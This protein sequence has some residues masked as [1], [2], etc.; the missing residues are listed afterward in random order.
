MP[1]WVI[2]SLAAGHE[3]HWGVLF[4]R[5]GV[6]FV[7]GVAV[8][9][10][11]WATHRRDETLSS[12]FVATLI[13]LSILI[14]MLT[15]V[16]GD[17]TARAFSLLGVLS[18]VRFR[19]IVEDTRDTAFV[20]FAVIIGMA[21]GADHLAVALAGLL[22]VGLAAM[23]M[24]PRRRGDLSDLRLSPDWKLMVR[25]GL[26][27]LPA[28]LEPLYRKHFESWQP[29]RTSTGRQGAAIDLSYRVRLSPTANPAALVAEL[30]Q[31]EGVQQVDLERIG[32]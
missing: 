14:A 31:V 12:S 13:M 2:N 6:A 9:G 7:L 4:Y 26:G 32:G 24:R 28:G 29:T 18:V 21:V 19:T 17:N 1:D 25:V 23:L 5:L 15:Q 22:V 11:Y 8:A 10:I 27:P 3:L 30:N 16:I 20:V